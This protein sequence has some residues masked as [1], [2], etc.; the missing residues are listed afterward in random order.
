[1]IPP[2]MAY[3]KEGYADLIPPN[4]TLVFKIELLDIKKPKKDVNFDPL[5]NQDPE[6]PDFDRHTPGFQKA[7]KEQQKTEKNFNYGD[8]VAE[9]VK[10]AKAKKGKEFDDEDF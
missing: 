8:F 10:E 9:K 5:E 6:M 7:W 4:A 2:S 1:M 3:G